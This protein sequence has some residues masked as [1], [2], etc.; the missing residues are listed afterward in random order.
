MSCSQVAQAYKMEGFQV[1]MCNEPDC[2]PTLDS[3]FT[4]YFV[5]V[6]TDIHQWITVFR[7]SQL[8]RLNQMV[9]LFH[10]TLGQSCESEPARHALLPHETVAFQ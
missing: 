3:P 1:T 8:E 5:I 9:N 6:R 7:Y 2:Q 10:N 4:V